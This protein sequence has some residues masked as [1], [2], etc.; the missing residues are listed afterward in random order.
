MSMWPA[1]LQLL[2]ARPQLLAEHGQAYA[3]LLGEES[4]QALAGWR[5]QLG[6]QL[7]AGLLLGVATVLA[8]TA[9][10]LAAALP[11]AQMPW[12]WLL[13]GLPLLPLLAAWACW[14]VA[15]EARPQVFVGLQ[16]Q[17]QADAALLHDMLAR[18]AGGAAP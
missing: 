13:L 8:G 14:R 16:E 5:R 4:G 6:W 17:L 10:L 3:Q 1:W 12:P 15:A 18:P 11:V 2:A 9:A 7:L